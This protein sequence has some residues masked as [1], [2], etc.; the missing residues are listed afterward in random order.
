MGHRGDEAESA[1]GLGDLD[2]SGIFRLVGPTE[3]AVLTIRGDLAQDAEQYRSLGA[4]MLLQ[5]DL[6]LDGDKLVLEGRLIDLAS[7]QT[8]VAMRPTRS[9][10]RAMAYAA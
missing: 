8:I 4:E 10:L 7:Q 1:A 9:P 3:L 6:K 5:N 2:K